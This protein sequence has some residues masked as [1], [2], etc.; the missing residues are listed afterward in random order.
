MTSSPLPF[1][2]REEAVRELTVV[3]ARGREGH[4]GVV[5]VTGAPGIGKTR[6]I[7]EVVEAASGDAT[8]GWAAGGPAGGTDGPF[9]VWIQALRAVGPEGAEALAQRLT[10]R[11]ID[12]RPVDAGALDDDRSVG[13]GELARLQLYDEVA[14]TLRTGGQRHPAVLVLDDLHLADPSSLALLAFV[15]APLRAASVTVLGAACLDDP[16]SHPASRTVLRELTRRVHHLALEALDPAATAALVASSARTGLSDDAVAAIHRRAEGNPLFVAELVRLVDGPARRPGAPTTGPE[17]VPDRVRD[18]VDRRL[19]HL[20]DT[21]RAVLE[22]AAVLGIAVETELLVAAVGEVAPDL[23]VAP[24]LREAEQAT[25]LAPRDAD[26]HRFVHALYRDAIHGSLPA[27]RRRQ[28]HASIAAVLDRERTTGRDVSPAQIA[29][30]LTATRDPA[31]RRHAIDLLREAAAGAAAVH[32]Y[33]DAARELREAISLVRSTT[34]PDAVDAAALRAELL[35]ELGAATLALG[36]L[37]ASRAAFEQAADHARIAGRP[38]LLARAA[39]GV[40]S[41]EAGFEVPLYDHRQLEL[42]RLALAALPPT[43][44]AWIA[45]LQAR[46]SVAASFTEDE[47]RRVALCETAIA[48]A[49][50]IG[51]DGALAAA[52][53][54]HCDAIA[55]PDHSEE[56][57]AEATEVLELARARG[58]LRTELLARRLRLVARL[59]RGELTAAR[60]DMDAFAAVVA[61]I[62]EPLVAW[63]PALWDAMRLQLAGR[64]GEAADATATV[65]TRGAEAHS[66]NASQLGDTQRFWLSIDTAD[67]DALGALQR[68]FEAT[69]PPATWA[70]AA[71]A[72]GLAELGNTEAAR[73][74][75]DRLETE[76]PDAPRDSEWLAMLSQVVEAVA[77]TGAHPIAAW[78]RDA[79]LP[80]RGRYVVEGIGAVMRGSVERPLGT[81]AALL[82]DHAAAVEHF[83]AAL[84]ANR[85]L[86]GAALVARTLRDAGVALRSVERL[87]AAA[88]LYR[89]LGWDRRV[90]ELDDHLEGWRGD[91]ALPDGA[92]PSTTRARGTFRRDGDGWELRWQD[93]SVRVRD[94]K[95]L[96]DLAW[97]L[98]H[99]GTETPALDLLTATDP[100]GAGRS[101]RLDGAGPEGDLGEVLDPQA[102][103]AYRRR[104]AT[105]EDDITE[106]TATGDLV[107]RERSE[108]ERDR[109][110]QELTAAYGLGGR[111]RRAGDPAER[112]R[113]TV[114]SRLRYT[115]DRVAAVHPALGRHLANSVRT[116]R[117]CSY[118]PEQPVDWEL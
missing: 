1:V 23:D 100:A 63:Y 97:L 4:G 84:A 86:G 56:R 104:L 67:L 34:V 109:L 58:D 60:V 21:G 77:R 39:I 68:D 41:G 46:L 95:G 69:M 96:H 108:D 35:L 36:D 64:A 50:Q 57:E 13:S 37:P 27:P 33:E 94:S 25:L 2:G 99:P 78:V 32:A 14:A 106:A 20:S 49:R 44:R 92:A 116:G 5:L 22:V 15:A 38:V 81:L 82:G 80:F 103:K 10:T 54:A 24:A 66:V 91:P 18:L 72:L 45:R 61:R 29:R 111:P 8:V 115:I 70:M 6:L 75:L 9:G 47:P 40:G 28:L 117:Y 110:V 59:E 55:G 73:V 90:T 12:D 113:T 101:V 17:A 71:M 19:V 107:R 7:Q 79:L 85:R 11:R 65:L 16:A 62:D 88:A 42:L 31:D 112:A 105:L 83:D 102:R 3:L 30:H 26:T 98:A 52:L 51:D 118:T 43:E 114:T 93:H 48:T 74:L 76:L 89:E 87:R 53:A